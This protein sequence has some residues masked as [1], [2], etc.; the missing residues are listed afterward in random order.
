MNWTQ[1]DLDRRNAE[2]KRTPVAAPP[3]PPKVNKYHVA[4]KAERTIDGITFASKAE[5]EAYG[6]LKLAELAG[7]I[8]ELKTQPAYVLQESFMDAEGKKHRAIWYIGD[9]EFIRDG[10]LVCVDVKGMKTSVFKLK[11]KMFRYKYGNSIKLELWSK[12]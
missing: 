12:R 4:P 10:Q 2:L 5:A 7:A 1:E 9:F 3:A 11:E 6:Q 8:S